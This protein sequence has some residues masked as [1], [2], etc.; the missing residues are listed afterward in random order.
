MDVTDH[1]EAVDRGLNVVRLN[2]GQEVDHRLG[3]ETGDCGRTNVLD[4]DGEVADCGGRTVAKPLELERPSR[5]VVDDDDRIR[6]G[7]KLVG[8]LVTRQLAIGRS[9]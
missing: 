8:S 3:G 7:V 9:P 6:H 1:A 5:A 2:Y 4:R